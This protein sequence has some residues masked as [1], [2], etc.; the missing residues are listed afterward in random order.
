[1][2]FTIKDKLMQYMKHFLLSCA[3]ENI[4]HKMLDE[5][6]EV[7]N[8]LTSWPSDFAVFSDIVDSRYSSV[9]QGILYDASL[10]VHILVLLCMKLC[11]YVNLVLMV[12]ARKV[13]HM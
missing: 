1:M 5:V 8:D 2:H 11:M 6:V 4:P 13:L 3:V 9:A 7:V 10:L 12:C